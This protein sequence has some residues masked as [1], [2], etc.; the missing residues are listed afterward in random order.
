[1]LAAALTTLGVLAAVSLAL[2]AVPMIL[3]VPS[4]VLALAYGMMLARG[5]LRR[6]PLV[7][8]WTNKPDRELWVEHSKYVETWRGARAVFRGGLVSLL[9]T[10]QSGRNRRL[11]WW[12][13]TLSSESRRRM[14]LAIQPGRSA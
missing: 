12:P 9:A 4:G 7:V 2:S 1:M 11:H 10:D 14:R 3:A 6:P 5:E 13:D 8:T